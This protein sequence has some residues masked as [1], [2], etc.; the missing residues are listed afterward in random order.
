MTHLLRLSSL[1]CT[2]FVFGLSACDSGGSGES[3]PESV[4]VRGTV[5]EPYGIPA[6]SSE[7]AVYPASDSST[8][9]ASGFTEQNGDYDLIFETGSNSPDRM[10][11]EVTSEKTATYVKEFQ[12]SAVVQEDVELPPISLNDIEELQAIDNPDGLP[13]N[14]H[15][16][17]SNDIDASATS[18][19]NGGRGFNPIGDLT[20]KGES[21][22]DLT[23]FT[24]TF[25]GNTH[26]IDDLKIDRDS[27]GVGL[28]AVVGGVD[29]NTSFI[30]VENLTLRNVNVQGNVKVGGFAGY[31]R[32]GVFRNVSSTGTVQGKGAVGGLLGKNDQGVIRNSSS[33]ADAS[34]NV[35]TGGL[36]GSN[37]GAV[38]NT[39]ASGS[40]TV[41]EA[42]GGG[43]VG[44]NSNSNATIDSSYASGS[45]TGTGSDAH[46]IGGLVG[47]QTEGSVY[48]SYSTGNVSGSLWVGGLVGQGN[49]VETSYSTGD[50]SGEENVGGL[51]GGLGGWSGNDSGLTGRVY[52]TGEVTGDQDV[53]GLIGFKSTDP[54]ISGAYWDQIST[55][56]DSATGT[57]S[58]GGTHGLT[59]EEMTGSAAEGNMSSLDF[60]DTWRTVSGDYPALRWE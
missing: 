43:L 41:T 54:D 52:A 11:L 50:V 8:T 37:R 5:L 60:E 51:M 2:V 6:E 48:S 26:A 13:L 30:L 28:F 19:W 34:G 3:G 22:E 14:G 39:H 35:T 31:S 49:I 47:D 12:L 53:G 17:L 15:Y 16:Q 36:V 9:L 42:R 20:G 44:N 55:M 21:S 4:T 29:I 25:D 58:D 7:V 46:R 1:L 59:T 56:Q 57:G 23:G 27:N 10:R 45:V 40:V 24:G 33:S 18:N 32:R 38:S